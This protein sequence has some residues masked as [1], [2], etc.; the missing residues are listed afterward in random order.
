MSHM[1]NLNLKFGLSWDT[2]SRYR[3]SDED[4]KKD[5]VYW[6]SIVLDIVGY[7]YINTVLFGLA[8]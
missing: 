3:F 8:C 5:F 7:L 4:Q 6:L 1:L 2:K